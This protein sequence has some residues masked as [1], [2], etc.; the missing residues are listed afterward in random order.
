MSTFLLIFSAICFIAAFGI[1][2]Y[3]KNDVMAWCGYMASPL[4]SAVPWISG[5]VLAVIPECL[6]FDLFWL[7]VFFINLIIV[8]VGG[9]LF[10]RI[11]IRMFSSGKGAGLDIL[12]ALIV[13]LVTLAIGASVI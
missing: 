1:H 4:F 13:G 9:P 2:M 3:A 7:W 11:F 6:L 5:Y 8:G 12:I 10:A